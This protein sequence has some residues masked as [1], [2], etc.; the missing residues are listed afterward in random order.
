MTTTTAVALYAAGCAATIIGALLHLAG[1]RRTSD[2]VCALGFALTASSC[3]LDGRPVGAAL[4]GAA[5]ALCAWSWWRGGGGKGGRRA[6]RALGAKSTALLQAL[7][8]RLT[9]PPA[10]TPEGGRA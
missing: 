9:P 10:P 3:A 7:T 6:A 5:A 8:R 4:F 2:A 1:D